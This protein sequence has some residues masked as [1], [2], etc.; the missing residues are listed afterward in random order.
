MK[1]TIALISLLTFTGVADAQPT[2]PRIAPPTIPTVQF[3]LPQKVC[4]NNSSGSR[5]CFH[6]VKLEERVWLLEGRVQDLEN[7]CRDF[8]RNGQKQP[9]PPARR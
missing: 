7:S 6:P 4:Y 5:F 1:R 9:L 8:N 3:W 2:D